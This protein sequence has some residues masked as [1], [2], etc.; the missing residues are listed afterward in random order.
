[1]KKFIDEASVTDVSIAPHENHNQSM[2]FQ[3]KRFGKREKY[4]KTTKGLWEYIV[5]I[6][7]EKLY[8]MEEMEKTGLVIVLESKVEFGSE[9]LQK[10]FRK[11]EFPFERLIIVA[12]VRDSVNIVAIW[13]ESHLLTLKL[14]HLEV[15][16]RSSLSQ[17]LHQLVH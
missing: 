3:L 11:E 1:M 17:H 5:N 6:P 8:S 10:L 4:E 2:R 13:P 9:E 15:S 12:S 16:F 14:P 7:G